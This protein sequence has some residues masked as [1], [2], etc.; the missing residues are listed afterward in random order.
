MKQIAL[1]GCAILDGN[2]LLLLRRKATGWL[3]LPGGKV[4]KGEEVEAAAIRE[5]QEELCCQVEIVRKLGEAGFEEEGNSFHYIWFL[6]EL[7]PNEEPQL[8]EPEKFNGFEW[9]AIKDLDGQKLSFNMEN[10]YTMFKEKKIILL[11]K[12]G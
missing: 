8:G 1:A 6:A 4:N 12:G 11:K 9:V 2:K 3:E 7:L 5:L 10:F